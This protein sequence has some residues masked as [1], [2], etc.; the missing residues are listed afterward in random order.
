MGRRICRVD[1]NQAEIVKKLRDCGAFVQS[2]AA[3]GGGVPDLLVGYRNEW[4]LLEIKSSKDAK[5]TPDQRVWHKKA[6]GK[7]I[8]WV[9]YDAETALNI[10][11]GN[12]LAARL[13]EHKR[14]NR[15]K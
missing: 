1:A 14:N 7:G 5:L 2:L 8:V 11:I 10:V 3:V 15:G 12:S 4:F 9:V 6:R 13:L